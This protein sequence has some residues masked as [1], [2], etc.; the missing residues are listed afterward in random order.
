MGNVKILDLATNAISEANAA[1][2]VTVDGVELKDS[3]IKLTSGADRLAIRADDASVAHGMTD[4]FPTTAYFGTFEV[5]AG[6]GGIQFVGMSDDAG[7]QGIQ[8][9]GIVGVDNP[10]DT[11]PGIVLMGAKKSGTTGTILGDAET[12][13]RVDNWSATGLIAVLGSGYTGVNVA[14]P[15]KRLE[16]RDGSAAQ[17]RLSQSSSVQTDLKTNSDGN[18]NISP[19]GGSIFAGKTHTMASSTTTQ[20]GLCRGGIYILRENITYGFTAIVLYAASAA[21]VIISQ[22]QA[23]VFVTS[24]SGSPEDEILVKTGTGSNLAIECSASSIFD[25]KDLVVTCLGTAE[26]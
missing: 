14:A 4:L 25:G 16:I 20:L 15:A 26:V 10:T 24:F 9:I 11:T 21:P 3:N 17:L 6:K 8:L 22:T 5:A 7:T 13:L 19:S 23:G 18:L 2:G 12:V 1:E